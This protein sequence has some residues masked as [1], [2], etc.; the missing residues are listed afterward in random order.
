MVFSPDASGVGSNPGRVAVARLDVSAASTCAGSSG[1]DGTWTSDAQAVESA[2][3]AGSI[4]KS[5]GDS[6]FSERKS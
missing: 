6:L 3:R 5:A 1:G 2:R 4:G